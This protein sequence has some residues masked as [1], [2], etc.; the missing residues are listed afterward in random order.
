MIFAEP[1]CFRIFYTQFN[2]KHKLANTI[3]K[4]TKMKK[5]FV[6][7]AMVMAVV[8][9]V[10][11]MG[12]EEAQAKQIQSAEANVSASDMVE[13]TDDE[14]AQLVDA[15]YDYLY[16]GDVQLLD[17]TTK[18]YKETVVITIVAESSDGEIAAD[19]STGTVDEYN[20]M[21]NTL[22][23]MLETTRLGDWM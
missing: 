17:V 9:S 1:F 6:A 12:P 13:C 16:G 5:I 14:L 19:T 20:L 2:D 8:M 3:E 7:F 4:G 21:V 11:A 15:Y 18:V 23:Q 22:R 10:M